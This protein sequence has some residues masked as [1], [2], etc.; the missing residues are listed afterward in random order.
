MAQTDRPRAAPRGDAPAQ[1]RAEA[2]TTALPVDGA[3]GVVEA[4]PAMYGSG[5]RPQPRHLVLPVVFLVVAAGALLGSHYWMDQT[6]YVSTDNARVAGALVQV[7][8]LNI[9]QIKSVNA[10]IGQAVVR[11]QV[12]ASV[13]LPSALGMTAAGMT[14]AGT[15][16]LGFVGSEDQQIP[17]RSP[18]DGVVVARQ[19]NPGDTVAAGQSILTLI[20]PS[21]LWVEA[22]IE[23][24]KVARVQPGQAVEVMVDSLG[25]SFPGRVLAVG[26]ASSATFSL[27]PQGNTSGNFIKVTQ[28]VPV[29]IEVDYGGLPLVLG[30]SVGVRI[31]VQE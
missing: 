18:I 31:R 22:R 10:D 28:L 2:P 6:L 3:G 17:I 25:Q 19:G 4:R 27:L 11:D 30:S 7:G 21:Q 9:G 24:T 12:V 13:L 15:A 29:K 1:Q 16:R 26:R 23:E 5:Q 8:A 20:N 14:A